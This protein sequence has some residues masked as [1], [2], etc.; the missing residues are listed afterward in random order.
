MVSNHYSSKSDLHFDTFSCGLQPNSHR[1]SEVCYVSQ[2]P[3][4]ILQSPQQQ[5]VAALKSLQTLSINSIIS[6]TTFCYLPRPLWKVG[7]YNQ[8]RPAN[9]ENCHSTRFQLF[10]GS[11][12]HCFFNCTQLHVTNCI[13]FWKSFSANLLQTLIGKIESTIH[14]SVKISTI[15]GIGSESRAQPIVLQCAQ[16]VT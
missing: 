10:A 4:H 11:S 12:S 5:I 9:I 8:A 16:K 15:L 3:N 2:W 6:A 13:R 1:R 14:K 7:N